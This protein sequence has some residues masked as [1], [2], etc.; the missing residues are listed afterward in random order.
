M[1]GLVRT[2]TWDR[3]LQVYLDSMRE[4]DEPCATFAAGAVHA[5]TG[6]DLLPAF[7]GRMSWA[8]DHLEA[9]VTEALG[10]PV[11]ASFARMGDVI[12]CDGNLG[13]CYGEVSFFMALHEGQF[14]TA[15]L[16]TLSCSAAWRV[17]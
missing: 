4:A 14:G 6:T 5:V 8:R 3:D 17:G 16:P 2:M 7:R 10:D 9:A 12:M 1:N 15:A 13:V 11:P